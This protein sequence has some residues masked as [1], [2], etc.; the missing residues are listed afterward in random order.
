MWVD[1]V[2]EIAIGRLN[3]LV[4]RSMHGLIILIK[5]IVNSLLIKV[6]YWLH[7]CTTIT[8][9]ISLNVPTIMLSKWNCVS[10]IG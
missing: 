10:I 7:S 2:D 9:S 3:V 6:L 1:V 5:T 4:R 8:S